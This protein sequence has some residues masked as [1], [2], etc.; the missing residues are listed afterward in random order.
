M[1]GGITHVALWVTDLE[2]AER[3]YRDLFGLAVAF[4][5]AQTADGWYTLPDDATWDD[6][7]VAGIRLDLAFLYRDT[8][9]LALERTD[10]GPS[11]GRLSHIGVQTDAATLDQLRIHA[12]TRGCIVRTDRPHALIFG[13]VYGVWWE[14]STL[15]YADPPRLSGGAR[16]GHWLSL[17][18]KTARQ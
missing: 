1:F 18:A 14:W 7:R 15:S 9:A 3:Y 6:A 5:E 11:T 12:P 10:D 2:A 4:R 13:D 8:F 17:P 16:A